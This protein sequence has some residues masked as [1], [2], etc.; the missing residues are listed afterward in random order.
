MSLADTVAKC[1]NHFAGTMTSS[2]VWSIRRVVSRPFFFSLLLCSGCADEGEVMY[3]Y[4]SGSVTWPNMTL[5]VVCARCSKTW[6][7]H[8]ADKATSEGA[9]INRGLTHQS[10]CLWRGLRYW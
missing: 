7:C 4:L 6:Q 1:Q 5:R 3:P 9:G 2:L 8:A 10:L